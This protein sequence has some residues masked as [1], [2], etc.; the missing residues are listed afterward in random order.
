MHPEPQLKWISDAPGTTVPFPLAKRFENSQPRPQATSTVTAL[1]GKPISR[2]QR[3]DGCGADSGLSLGEPCRPAFRPIE[4]SIALSQNDRFTSEPVKLIGFGR[5]RTMAGSLMAG[6]LNDMM[7]RT[8]G[9][10]PI[11]RRTRPST[12][13]K[14]AAG[15]HCQNCQNTSRPPRRLR[16]WGRG[17]GGR[18]KG[19]GRH[20]RS[21]TEVGLGRR[22]RG[23]SKDAKWL[24]HAQQR[25][26]LIKRAVS[27]DYEDQN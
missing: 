1:A 6:S 2:S 25:G 10:S 23:A 11:T 8:H 21:R 14:R 15:A 16:D 17:G 4:A 13:I 9:R 5:R 20:P 27:F 24:N 7:P 22:R 18:P 12:K 3:N 19:A 26:T